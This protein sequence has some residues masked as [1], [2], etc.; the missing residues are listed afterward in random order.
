M[1]RPQARPYSRKQTKRVRRALAEVHRAEARVRSIVQCVAQHD[2]GQCQL[3]ASHG[4][5]V[6]HRHRVLGTN[7]VVEW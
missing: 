3:T 5:R 6:K 4:R 7:D 2:V 1:P